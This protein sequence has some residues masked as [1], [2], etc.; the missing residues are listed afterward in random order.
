VPTKTKNE[1]AEPRARKPRELGGN[2]KAALAEGRNEARAI[3]NY[4][5]ALDSHKP[6]RGRKRTPDSIRRRLDA[7]A[8]EIGTARPLDRLHMIQER[9]DLESEL[10][11]MTSGGP[12]MAALEADFVK[13]A[14]AYS[15]RKNITYDAWRQLGV[16]ASTLRSAGV[17]R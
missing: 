10:E 8:I 12:D 13:F 11:T 7:I 9:M 4:L 6:K 14:S 2:H 3:R 15:K 1:K 17:G 5:E 16:T